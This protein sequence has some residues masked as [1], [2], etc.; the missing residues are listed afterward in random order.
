MIKPGNLFIISFIVM[1]LVH[2]SNCFAQHFEITNN[3]KKTTV[4]FK[5]KRNLIVVEMKVNNKGP[6]NF[7]VDSGAG[8]LLITD[9]DIIDTLNLQSKRIIRVSGITS[10]ESYEAIVPEP[11]S[12]EFGD[13]KS[14]QVTPAILKED[15]F[16]ISNYAGIKIHGLLGYEFFSK[17]KVKID[18]NDSLMTVYSGKKHPSYN[19]YQKIPIEIEQ[20]K[21]FVTANINFYNGT[22]CECKLVVDIGAGHGLSLENSDVKLW[23]AQPRIS[24]NLGRGLTGEIRGEISRV[25]SIKLGRHEL[26]NPIS[27]FPN[28]LHSSTL[29]LARDG[30]LGIDILKRFHIVLDYQNKNMYIKSR[31]SLKKPFEHDMSGLE[32]YVDNENTGAI[33][34]SRVEP[35]SPGDIYGILVDDQLLTVNLMPVSKLG[36]E[37][38]DDMFKSG[39]GKNLLLEVFR[40]NKIERVILTLK[41]RI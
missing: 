27:A 2:S 25:K 39:S 30:N 38:L 14:V 7:I 17:L 22:S 19:K 37:K 41:R 34:V 32:Y 28:N 9:P 35:G 29:N 16:G 5:I 10:N 3:K 21:S 15:Y 4:P 12:F 6:Y 11:Q 23:P 1:M 18:F 13:L 40:N 33:F 24:A 20:K 8:L 36:V 26:N 31:I